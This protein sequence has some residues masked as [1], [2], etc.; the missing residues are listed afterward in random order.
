MIF[1]V[2]YAV[3]VWGLAMHWRRQWPAAA[4]VIIGLC[5]LILVYRLFVAMGDHL[6][7]YRHMLVLFWPYTVFVT[8]IATY[9]ACLPRRLSDT[10]CRSCAYDLHGLDMKNL[11]CPECGTEWQGQG[12]GKEPPPEPLIPIP[13][14]PPMRRRTLR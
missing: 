4:A 6:T 9:I 1:P 5:G 3:V 12:S 2:I 11:N 10:Q 8:A 7:G 14:G 13:T